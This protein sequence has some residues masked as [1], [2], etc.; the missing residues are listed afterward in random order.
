VPHDQS[1]G[2]SIRSDETASAISNELLVKV[3]SN[4]SRNYFILQTQ[5]NNTI[6]KI[7][8]RLYD[9][10]GRLLEVKNNIA[11]GSLVQM[12]KTL[13]AGFYILEYSQANTV[14]QTTL[15]KQ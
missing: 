14:K 2:T 1:K 13:S 12:G 5:S 6:Q 9:I 10:S 7:N 15:I 11:A 3:Q 8:L 4:P